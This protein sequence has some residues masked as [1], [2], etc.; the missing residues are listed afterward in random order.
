MTKSSSNGFQMKM[1]RVTPALAE[2][3]LGRND[4][5]RNMSK[6]HANSL[7]RAM[8][9]GEWRDTGDPIQLSRD[10]RLQNGQHRLQAVVISGKTQTFLVIEGV[11]PES[12]LVMDVG[13]KRSFT[14]HLRI[15]GYQYPGTLAAALRLVWAYEHG[16]ASRTNVTSSHLELL[17]LLEK[18]PGIKDSASEGERIGRAVR[19][20]RGLYAAT[21]WILLNV[22]EDDA[23]FFF[24]RLVDGA[25]LLPGDA[26]FAL[27]RL[28]EKD[29]FAPRKLHTT[30]R[31]ALIIK[32]WNAYRQGTPVKTLIWRRGG[33]SPES[34]PVP[35]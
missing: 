11:E 27:R 6:N 32:A 4:S 16:Q 33:A 20:S 34:F 13:R 28:L 15:S 12:Q 23:Q 26:I 10:G 9:Q 7:A 17:D 30:Q 14:D 35:V 29:W 2:R 31:F 5:N 8:G 21:H 18:N 3:Y 25:N 1:V 24:D 22:D 19:G